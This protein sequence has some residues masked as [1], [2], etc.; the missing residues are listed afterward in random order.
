M[1]PLVVTYALVGNPNTGKSTLFNQLTGLNQKI[2]NYPGVT[3]ERREG[4]VIY[5]DDVAIT[6]L[7]LPGTYS[8]SPHSP[9]EALVSAILLG[10]HPSITKP[11][12]ILCIVSALALERGLYLASHII[13]Q[14]Y[15]IL[16]VLT[17]T[18][19]AHQNG[20]AINIPLLEQRLGVRIV[21]T[22]ADKGIGID[23][24]R[25]A[26]R[27]S[28]R[29]SPAVR[30]WKLPA[31]VEVEVNELTSLLIHHAHIPQERALFEATTLL[32][33][34]QSTNPHTQV[35]DRIILD[36]VLQDH[37]R[38]DALGYDRHSLFIQSR[39]D[40]IRSLCDGVLTR[41]RKSTT[42]IDSLDRLLLTP[43]IGYPLFA[44]SMVL[45][46]SAVYTWASYPMTWIEEGISWSGRVLM[47]LLPE[48]SFRSLL[49]DGVLGGT[50]AV[51]VFLPQIAILFF[52]LSVLEESGYMA[53]AAFLLDKVMRK[54]GLPGKAFIPLLSSFACAV[55]GI[56]ATRTLENQRDR[57]I[58]LFVAPLM[59]CSARLP[60]YTLLIAATIPANVVVGFLPL[61]ALV[62]TSLY[63]LG[64][65]LAFCI[66]FFLRRSVVKGPSP[67]LL[68]ELPPYR[69]P[70]M[71]NVFMNMWERSLIF[72]KRAG[73]IILFASIVLWYFSTHPQI[74]T[75]SPSE[76]LSMSYLGTAGR[77]LE[78]LFAPLGYDWK[79]GVAL[80]S[81][82][83]QRELFI[84]TINTLTNIGSN[85]LLVLSV[86]Q[87]LNNINQNLP[88][89]PALSVLIF[90][91]IAPQCLSTIAVI[92]RETNSWQWTIFFI[93]FY[94]ILA[95]GVALLV[96]NVGLYLL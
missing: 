42:S 44:L 55:P 60:V 54:V 78:P 38:L 22:I 56:L 58:T 81:S 61:Q 68:I 23:N 25:E 83:L 46:F 92:Q 19:L 64:I 11:N 96:Y 89:L 10:K 1:N 29:I 40:W 27:T 8:L 15:P 9:D 18:D 41:T 32:S 65:V 66:T 70:L 59:S 35:F 93:T 13:D 24:V 31:D 36:H 39:I 76:Q 12:G 94:T 47:D 77:I 63:F 62:L 57:I 26:L 17:M 7:D 80:L 53:R 28:L 95:Y 75:A 79:I 30:Q 43:S 52:L 82:F 90:F 91:A 67:D 69:L 85:D 37:Q 73:T 71:K 4:R 51:L 2:G 16:I 34:N 50:G 48:S 84:S 45:L 72:L 88:T 6:L 5:P 14:Q 49:L 21:P 20:I 86:H 74:P 87:H 3:V 33:T